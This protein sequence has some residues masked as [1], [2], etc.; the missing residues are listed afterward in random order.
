MNY[1]KKSIQNKKKMLESNNI[2]R[3]QKMKLISFRTALVLFLALFAVTGGLG[4]GIFRGIIDSAPKIS[5]ISIEPTG[6]ITSICDKDGK[7][8]QTLS[9]YTSN[10]IDVSIDQMPKQLQDA[11]VA[12][13]DARFYEHKGID[14][15]GMVRALFVNISHGTIREGASTITQQ[16]IKNNVFHVGSG[17]T[18]AYSRIRRKIQE[19]YLALQVEKKFSKSEIL[20]NYLNTINLGQGTL[21][22]QAASKQYFDK[23]VSKLTLSECAVIAAITRNPTYY[24]PVEYPEHNKERYEKVLGKMLTQEMIT[25]EEYNEALKDDVYERIQKVNSKKKDD[26]VYSYFVDALIKQVVAD[27]QN[28]LNYTQTQAY[29]LLYSGGLTIYSTQ[30]RKL[31]KIVDSVIND[32]DNYPSPKKL[33]LNYRLSILQ[34]DGT[35]KNYSEYDVLNYRKGKGKKSASLIYSSKKKAKKDVEAFRKSVVK[36]GDKITGETFN[37][38]VQPQ[39]S[40]TLIDQKTGKVKALA[41]GRG[42]KTSNLALNRSTGAPRQ[43]GSTFKPLSTYLPALDTMGK[44][45]ATVYDDAP[46]RYTGT[47]TKVKNWYSGYYRGLTTVRDAITYS[48]NIITAKTMAD[49]TPQV[50]YDYLLKLGFTTLVDH[51]VDENGKVH[52]DIVQP[53]AL[54]G[55]TNGVTNMELTAAYA[56]IA[57]QGV[58]V[59]PRLY[60]KIMDHEGNVLYKNKKKSN[61]VMKESTAWLLTDAM[62]DVIKKGTGTKAQLN[63]DM[64]VAGKTGTTSNDVDFWFSGYT[65]YYTASIWMGYDVNKSFNGGNYHKIIWKKI[66]DQ[67]IDAKDQKIKDFPDCKDIV[68]RT[69]CTKSGRLAVKGLCDHDAGGGTTRVEYFAK[70]TQPKKECNVH[71]KVTICKD[72]N[73]PAGQYCPATS[74]ITKVYLIKDEDYDAETWD[75]PNVLPSSI[76]KKTC[77]VHDENSWL[78]EQMK[79]LEDLL[80]EDEDDEDGTGGLDELE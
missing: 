51:E 4:F 21:G 63:S 32:E 38:V 59:K 5:E 37:M 76:K 36:E 11:F 56:A 52:S 8:I 53:L 48:L 77:N 47:K 78:E 61:Q 14:I 45:L 3:K 66:M 68:K 50:G 1:N 30:D 64:P 29:N 31:Q 69:I 35:E 46:Y 67:A 62:K 33:S 24:D 13:E 41:G 28:E 15:K 12:I 73:L 27:L 55:I 25:E 74:Q 58:Y 7:E 9:D 39:A 26:G 65:P 49:V 80:D 20:K 75:T 18:N 22:V 54:G 17:E 2:R 16:L 34:T 19:Q 71:T 72:S 42:E 57:N 10:R 43:P 6:F 44:T 40:F 60:T 23:D 79:K 70:G